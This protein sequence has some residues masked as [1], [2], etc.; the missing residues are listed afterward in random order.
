[1]PRASRSARDL[2]QLQGNR[3]AALLSGRAVV[4]KPAISDFQ[5]Q[6]VPV[7]PDRGHAP[8]PILCRICRQELSPG[9]LPRE[10]APA[11]VFQP[12]SAVL[13]QTIE[14]GRELRL[15]PFH[16][17]EPRPDQLGTGGAQRPIEC[18]RQIGP[19]LP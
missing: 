1:M 9:L 16:E 6:V 3:R 15:G 7:R 4:P 2:D 12:G 19:A 5:G 14:L 11:A 10:L 17:L 13:A 8:H 18:L